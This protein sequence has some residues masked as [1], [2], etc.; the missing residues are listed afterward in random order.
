MEGGIAAH[1]RSWPGRP[2]DRRGLGRAW[3]VATPGAE[4]GGRGGA[5]PRPMVGAWLTKGVTAASP[6]ALP[7]WRGGD[8]AFPGWRSVTRPAVRVSVLPSANGRCRQGHR[9]AVS[10][11]TPGG[12]RRVDARLRASERPSS[13]ESGGRGHPSDVVSGGV[14]V[15]GR[16]QGGGV[17]QRWVSGRRA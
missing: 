13:E 15:R 9:F 14:Q 2:E 8:P 4:P 7:I 12:L 5:G 11:R 16:A 3:G 6:R 1:S 10:L 17:P